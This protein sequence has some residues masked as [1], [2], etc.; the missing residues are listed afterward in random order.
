METKT[1]KRKRTWLEKKRKC[2]KKEVTK[3]KTIQRCVTRKKKVRRFVTRKK[4][5]V[6][7]YLTTQNISDSL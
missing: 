3:K 1:S 2:K 5:N 7:R 4:K 6:Q